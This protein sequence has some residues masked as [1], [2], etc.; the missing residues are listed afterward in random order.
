MYEFDKWDYVYPAE[1]ADEP[2]VPGQRQKK[3]GYE[4]TPT[5]ELDLHRLLAVSYTLSH[6]DV[7][8]N[9]SSGERCEDCGEKAASLRACDAAFPSNL[10]FS[11]PEDGG[12]NGKQLSCKRAG[13]CGD[14]DTKTEGTYWYCRRCRSGPTTHE[15]VWGFDID[16]PRVLRT[17]GTLLGT[18]GT[19]RGCRC[20]G[21]PRGCMAQAAARAG[22]KHPGGGPPF[23][24]EKPSK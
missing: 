14:C 2:A 10:A 4:A 12:A 17:E 20:A 15:D 9:L 23:R 3:K 22:G 7:L 13:I 24:P 8:H 21:T 6:L 18:V 16:E 5:F 19:I 11:W 1:F